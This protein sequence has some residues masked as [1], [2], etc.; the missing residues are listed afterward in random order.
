MIRAV[1]LDVDGIIVGERIGYNS[2]DPH[3]DVVTRLRM[4]RTAGIPVVLCTGK[5]QY[6]V[7]SIIGGAALDN[8]HIAVSGSVITESAGTRIIKSWVM[9]RG[10]VSDVTAVCLEHGVY[11]ELYAADRYYIQSSQISE[12]TRLHTHILK[13]PPETVKDLLAVARTADIIRVMPIAD[14]GRETERVKE[15]LEP[16]AGRV[17]TAW[18]LHPVANPRQFCGVTSPGVSKKLAATV[19]LDTLGIPAGDCLSVGDS[20]RDW[21]YMEESGYVA[22]L[23]NGQEPL[24]GLV[25]SRGSRGFVGGHVDENGILSVFDHFRLPDS[26]PSP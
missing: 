1:I 6:S 21:S 9:E 2:P 14:N 26:R 20:T 16:F 24:K 12:T 15:L 3:P 11:T 22:T 5:P 18:G 7:S 8:P 13:R 10:L 23:S 25:G 4:I 19:V 17:S